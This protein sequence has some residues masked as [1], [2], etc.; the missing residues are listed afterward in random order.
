MVPRP[1][2]A[3][4]RPPGDP[5]SDRVRGGAGAARRLSPLPLALHDAGCRG[6]GAALRDRPGCARAVGGALR[7]RAQAAGGV[8]ARSDRVPPRS[9]CGGRGLVRAGPRHPRAPRVDPAA[10][11]GPEWSAAAS[12]HRLDV[13]AVGDP[14]EESGRVASGAAAG[15]PAR[16]LRGREPEPRRS[17]ARAAPCLHRRARRVPAPLDRGLGR[18]RAPPAGRAPV[19]HGL[20]RA[21][22][23]A[24]RRRGRELA[25]PVPARSGRRVALLAR[26]GVGRRRAREA[27]RRPRRLRPGQGARRA[28]DARRGPRR[29]A[30]R[31][32]RPVRPRHGRASIG[33]RRARPP[34][35]PVAV[36]RVPRGG[37]ALRRR[38]GAGRA[39]SRRSPRPA[40]ARRNREPARSPRK[41]TGIPR[42]WSR[43]WRG[44]R[45]SR[46]SA[47]TL[48]SIPSA[49][50]SRAEARPIT[51]RSRLARR[52]RGR[53]VSRPRGECSGSV[54]PERTPR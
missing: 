4:G 12:L 47:R 1:P 40:R 25:G 10:G 19:A 42:R 18:S 14:R 23:G 26:P 44:G 45:S 37:R 21:A 35:R 39:R 36:A 34:R 43:A 24:R 54:S 50:T 28:E 29:P 51:P 17:V 5:R 15:S 11:R 2:R 9:G 41:P 8:A 53:R 49:S 16:A 7:P 6:R 27:R 32:W 22:G 33:A 46:R 3:G 20:R 48:R 31:G 52:G 30:D 13:G 38:L